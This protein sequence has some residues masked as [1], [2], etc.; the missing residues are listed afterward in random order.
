[1]PVAYAHHDVHVRGFVHEVIIGYGNE[2][3]ARHKRSYTSADMI[4]DPL[5]SLS[6]LEQKMGAL[7]QAAPL[8]GWNLP[9]VFTTLNR[10]LEAR[11]SKPSKREY[12]QVLRI[13]EAFEMDVVKASIGQAIDLG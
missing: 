11:M 1:V 7:D 3:I 13:L 2:I 9:D 10:L 4:F 8:Q 12:V 5:H 6:L